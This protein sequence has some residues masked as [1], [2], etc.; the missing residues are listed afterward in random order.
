MA[1]AC[2]RRAAI[3]GALAAALGARPGPGAAATGAPLRVSP[4]GHHFVYRGRVLMLLG[5][6]GTQVVPMNA[7]LDYRAWIDRCRDE[8]HSTVHVWAFT[9]A[10]PGDW[11]LGSGAP[12]LPWRRRAD[13]AFDLHA[14]DDGPE[15]SA[16]YWPRMRGMAR[17]ARARGL[18]F[19][20]TVLFGWAKDSGPG[21]GWPAHPFRRANGG[22]A[23]EARDVARL[24]EDREVHADPWNDEWPPARKAQ[25]V[26]ERFCLRLIEQVGGHDNTWFDYRDEWSYLNDEAE[27]SQAHWRRF[28]RGRGMLWADR[29]SRADFRVAN[30]TVPAFG[31]TPAMKTEGEPYDP[32]GVRREAWRRAMSGVHYLLHQDARSPNVAAWDPEMARARGLDPRDDPGRRYVGHCARFFNAMVRCLDAMVPAPG[33]AGP[34]AL[35]MAAPGEEAVVYAPQGA[36]ALALEL[37]AL[38]GRLL[39]RWYDPRSGRTGRAFAL[40]GGGRVSLPAPD[41]AG[42][43]V[44]LVTRRG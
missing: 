2:T 11:R 24:A 12:L 9:G 20:V 29:S 34:R 32:D 26:W 43:H 38:P 1:S 31:A 21:P 42:D 15:G 37:S 35:C 8:G 19:G 36:G 6:S 40:T 39:A 13:G 18:L 25:W 28:F 5:D 41:P 3:G 14:P 7:R 10:R 27:R 22:F 16:R 44:L 4:S 33:M 30:P 23:E 17:H